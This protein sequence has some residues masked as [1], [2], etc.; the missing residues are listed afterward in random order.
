MRITVRAQVGTLYSPRRLAWISATIRSRRRL[1]QL[2]WAVVGSSGF[3]LL[4]SFG[5]RR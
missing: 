4:G 3:A 1:S 5:I 2:T